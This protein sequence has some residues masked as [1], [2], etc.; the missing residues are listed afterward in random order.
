MRQES[1][2]HRPHTGEV[3]PDL[4]E[5]DLGGGQATV[6]RDAN[7]GKVTRPEAER[8]Q[9]LIGRVHRGRPTSSVGARMRNRI[10]FS[11]LAATL[12]CGA[13]QAASCCS[14]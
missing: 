1:G 4:D 8:D 13:F 11:A 12:N 3:R 2:A 9:F 7:S 5:A 10:G 6:W 14:S